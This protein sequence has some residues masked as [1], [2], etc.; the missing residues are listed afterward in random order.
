MRPARSENLGCPMVRKN[1]AGDSHPDRIIWRAP[2]VAPELWLLSRASKISSHT[3]QLALKTADGRRCS[4]A[5]ARAKED[6]SLS[7]MSAQIARAQRKPAMVAVCRPPSRRPLA[8]EHAVSSGDAY[9]TCLPSP[10]K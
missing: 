1:V 6:D 2:C 8:F 3:L 4:T 5:L 7:N 10:W 9:D